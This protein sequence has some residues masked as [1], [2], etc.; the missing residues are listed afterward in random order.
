MFSFRLIPGHFALM[1]PEQI[2]LFTGRL[3]AFLFILLK[4]LFD[5]LLRLRTHSLLHDVAACFPLFS[6]G[7]NRP[8]FG[9]FDR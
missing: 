5:N 3:N 7:I 1:F 8:M 9:H 4:L 2:A 6:F